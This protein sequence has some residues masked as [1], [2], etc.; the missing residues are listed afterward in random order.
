VKLRFKKGSWVILP[1]LIFAWFYPTQSVNAV[2][3]PG[4]NITVYDNWTGLNN[5]YNNAPPI[6]PITPVCSTTTWL[7]LNKNFNSTPVCNLYDDFQIK[8]EGYITAP[9]TGTYTLYMHGDDGVK[10]YLDDVLK[11]NAWYDSGNAGATTSVSFIEGVPQKL[12]GWYYENGGGNWV[13]LEYLVNGSWT[14]VPESWFTQTN[15]P[16]NTTTTTT[17]STTTSTTTTTTTT[18]PP[19][20]T[21]TVAPYF[22]A[23]Q[24]FTATAN[25]DG[26]VLLDWDAP[27]ASNTEIYGY[28]INFVDYDNNVERGGWGIW[29]V[30]ANT[31]YSLG[32]WMFDGN[33]PVTT[34]YGQ[35]RFK[36]YAMNGPCA[37]VGNGSCLYG[38][39]TNADATVLDPTPPTTTTTSTTTTSTTTTTTTTTIAPDTTVS[40][41]TITDSPVTTTTTEVVIITP[42]APTTTVEVINTPETIPEAPA[43]VFPQPS[44]DVIPDPEPIII[45]IPAETTSS[46]PEEVDPNTI[47]PDPNTAV[48][49]D[50]ALPFVP[51][52]EPDVT[53]PLPGEQISDNELNNILDDA[54]TPDASTEEITA[55]LDNILSADLSTEQ[56]TA[57]MDAVL[58]DT[59]DTE[60]VSEILVSLLSSNLSGEELTIVMDTVFSAEAS[61]EEMGAIVENL[62]NSDLS[63][64]ELTAVFTAAFDGDL[65]DAE[66]ISLA[67]D[68][69][70]QPVSTEELTA[71]ITAIFDEVVSDEV[72]TSTF[73]AVLEQPLTQ[74][75]FAAVVNV[76]E[77]DTISSDQVSQVVDLVINQDG[78]V[79]ADQATEL[80]TSPKVLESIDGSQATEVFDAIVVSEVTAEDGLAISLALVDAST[81]VKEAFEE[82]L[83]IF[84]GV[85]DIYVP[86]G[87]SINVGVR[88]T[89]VAVAAITTTLTTA[90]GAA[91]LSGGSSG[92]SGGSPAG[93]GGMPDNQKSSKI[94]R[95]KGQPRRR[96]K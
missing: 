42:E 50:E 47:L 10:L 57:V 72:L 6:P 53:I 74:E 62:L 11:V 77:S 43:E 75:A 78:G 30:A 36:V 92:G 68:V 83:N 32:H 19:T 37:G 1:A 38:P 44:P 18:I 61:V 65:S 76:L 54:F 82:Q 7:S 49:P 13:K 8:I 96:I 95:R 35:V 52:L 39:S 2:S 17:T 28:S 79:S 93:G 64:A 66:T 24:N 51:N 33:N 56:F 5:Y 67:Q 26:S 90:A 73:T 87:S 70:S 89:F 15:E 63:S 55:A 45:E 40:V 29:T 25:A 12:L 20:T 71:V 80:A 22:N 3:E 14:P 31:S 85:F 60:Q 81:E 34:G 59:S 4:L 88:R 58:A 16:T 84:E 94:K 46:I 21:T 91:P 23:I 48:G 69:L 9:T 27:E 41:T 86:T